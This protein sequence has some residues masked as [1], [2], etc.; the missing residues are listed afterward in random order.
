MQ[1]TTQPIKQIRTYSPGPWGAYRYRDLWDIPGLKNNAW[2]RLAGADLSVLANFS[3]GVAI[4]FPSMN[5]LKKLGY[6][7]LGYAPK[8]ESQVFGRWIRENFL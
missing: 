8:V 5:L 6:E 3:N 4:N 2:N 1:L 7:D